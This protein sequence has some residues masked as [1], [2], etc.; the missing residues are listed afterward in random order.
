MTR[1]VENEELMKFDHDGFW[2]PMDSH[3]EYKLLNEIYSNNKAEW[4][5]W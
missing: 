3:K 1:L 4:K 2:Q 5:I